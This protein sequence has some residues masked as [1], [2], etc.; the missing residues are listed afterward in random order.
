MLSHYRKLNL[1]E[2]ARAETYLRPD[3]PLLSL[4]S[5]CYP[6]HD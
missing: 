5:P 3:I 1:V 4:D 6:V 2:L